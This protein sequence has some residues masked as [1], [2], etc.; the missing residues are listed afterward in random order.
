MRFLVLLGYIMLAI[1]FSNVFHISQYGLFAVTIV[2]C[3]PVARQRIGKQESYNKTSIDRQRISKHTSLK[4]EAVF[5]AWSVQ[6][7]YK[8]E[9]RGIENSRVSRRHAPRI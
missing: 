8:E 2:T 3:I 1:P 4:I 5:S 7:G 9:F 6:S